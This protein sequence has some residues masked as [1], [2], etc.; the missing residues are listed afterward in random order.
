MLFQQDF[1]RQIASQIDVTT[2]E[3][4]AHAAS[5]DLAMQLIAPLETIRGLAILF[6]RIE[7]VFPQGNTVQLP[8]GNTVQLDLAAQTGQYALSAVA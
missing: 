3:D 4:R 6:W 8:Q 1:D 2:F 7:C 5:G